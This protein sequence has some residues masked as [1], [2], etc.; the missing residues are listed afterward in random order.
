MSLPA[1]K[2][3]AVVVGSGAAGSAIAAKLAVGGKKVVILEAGPDRDNQSL[4]SSAIWARRLKWSG[5]PVIEEGE[6]PIGHAF[7]AGYGVGG[8]AMHHYAVW[9]RLH[10]EDFKV[11]SLYDRARDWPISYDDLRPY[12]DQVQHESGIAG[13]AEQ[14]IWRPPGEPY[15]MP[16]VPLF[17]QGQI[18]ARGFE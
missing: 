9:P 16:P 13:D 11:R 8:S 17:A 18:I 7:N 4:I 14:E 1:E 10:G 6:N 15:P 5:A 2:V 3:D 12:Y